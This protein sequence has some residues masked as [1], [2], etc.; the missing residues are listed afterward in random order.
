MCLKILCVV[1]IRGLFPCTLQ[2]AQLLSSTTK[3]QHFH[4]PEPS[5]P[6]VPTSSEPP[7]P[8][9]VPPPPPPPHAPKLAV[10]GAEGSDKLNYVEV[11]HVV[12]G[13]AGGKPPPPPPPPYSSAAAVRELEDRVKYVELNPKQP[14]PTPQAKSYSAPVPAGVFAQIKL[15]IHTELAIA[16]LQLTKFGQ[17]CPMSG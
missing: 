7:L 2:E 9:T 6:P 11:Q 3:F 5:P 1:I 4:P 17:N 13:A 12:V 10:A 8:P 15:C 16:V 14:G